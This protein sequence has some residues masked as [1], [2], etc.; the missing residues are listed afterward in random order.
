[1]RDSAAIATVLRGSLKSAKGADARRQ[2]AKKLARSLGGALD[3]AAVLREFLKSANELAFDPLSAERE[4]IDERS[5]TRGRKDGPRTG[6][7]PFRT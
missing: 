4:G 5:A 2:T 3:T 7:C 6:T 1:V